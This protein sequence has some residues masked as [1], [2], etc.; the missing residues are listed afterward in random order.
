MERNIGPIIGAV[1]GLAPWIIILVM[2]V[3][4]I[5]NPIIKANSDRYIKNG[6]NCYNN[7]YFDKNTGKCVK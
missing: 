4:S 6:G 3:I 7:W 5:A 1:A 2:I